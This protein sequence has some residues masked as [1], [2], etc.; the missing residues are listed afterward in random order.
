LLGVSDKLFAATDLTSTPRMERN[1]CGR[2]SLGPEAARV[3]PATDLSKWRL[4]CDRGRQ[5]WEYLEEEGV[6][7][8]EQSF[9][10]RH[11]LGLDTVRN[12]PFRHLGVWHNNH[13]HLLGSRPGYSE[14]TCQY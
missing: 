7:N 9:I 8:R 11:S 13:T 12:I 4:H 3:G 2:T 6:E 14:C 10:E 5:T 1:S